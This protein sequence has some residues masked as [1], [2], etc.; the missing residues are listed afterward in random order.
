MKPMGL[1]Q[2]AIARAWGV[3]LRRVNEI[4][5]GKRAIALDTLLRLGRYFGQSPR[6]PF[7]RQLRSESEVSPVA[8]SDYA[9]ASDPDRCEELESR[10]RSVVT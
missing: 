2:N 5:H 4:V 6:C 9:R 1:A 10:S 7:C 8:L 3:P